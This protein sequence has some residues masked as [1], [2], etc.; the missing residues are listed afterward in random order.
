MAVISNS[1]RFAKTL[2]GLAAAAALFA[3]QGIA[4]A[5]GKVTMG[6][7]G[8]GSAQQWLVWGAA[9]KGFFAQNGIALDPIVTP[10]ASAV[11]QQIL[12]GSVDIGSGGLTEP[13]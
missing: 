8:A 5:A 6:V 12:A 13:V 1:S 2:C 11:M 4:Q 10:S 3:T 7:I 9:K